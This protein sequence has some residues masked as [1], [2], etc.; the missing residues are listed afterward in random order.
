MRAL[1]LHLMHRIE[2]LNNEYKRLQ[3]THR[4]AGYYNVTQPLRLS[5]SLLFYKRSGLCIA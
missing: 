2:R 4:T 3:H 5:F 1:L